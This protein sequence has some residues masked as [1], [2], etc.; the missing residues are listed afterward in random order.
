MKKL[1]LR[2]AEFVSVVWRMLPAKLRFGF[3]KGLIVLETRG[4]SDEALKRA[5]SLEDFVHLAI[6][7]RAL[8]YGGGVH[9]KHRL[10]KYHDFFVERID[11][12][13]HVLDVGCS[14]GAVARSVA[15]A[16]P[17]S[18]VLGV[19]INEEKCA[20]A[21]AMPDKPSNL[22]FYRGDATKSVPAGPW[23]VVILSNV[24][25]HISD[26]I[27]FLRS[28][29]QATNCKR[30]LLR[31]PHFDRDWSMAMRRELG[32]GYYSD[33]DHKIE[34]TA[35]EFQHE[36]LEA[37]LIIDEEQHCWGEIWAATTVKK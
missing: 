8:A 14:Y 23:D 29:I 16:R 37:G 25:E 33:D 22:S 6:N 35:K 12:G 19:E 20:Q 28:L 34:H 10:T 13:S 32:V 4:K 24:L 2:I 1:L 5:F 21:Q 7:E 30:I 26:R 17:N 9:P 15:V 11:D 27:G 31:V 18:V 36:M 3:I